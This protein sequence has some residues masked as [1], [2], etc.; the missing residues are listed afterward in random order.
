MIPG[1]A[2]RRG[3]SC[4]ASPLRTPGGAGARTDA[5]R[6]SRPGPD[7]PDAERGQRLRSRRDWHGTQRAASGRA[8]NLLSG[9]GAPQSAQRP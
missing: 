7:G 2:R 4:P 3:G 5:G 8:S 1:G 9:T 6:G